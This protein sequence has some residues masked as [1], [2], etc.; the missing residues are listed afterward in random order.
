MAGGEDD[1]DLYSDEDED[2]GLYSDD[3]ESEAEAE[4]KEQ[5]GEVLA[6]LRTLTIDGGASAAVAADDLPESD[7]R[8]CV[9]VGVDQIRR[10]QLDLEQRGGGELYA[11]VRAYLEAREAKC[12]D[13][14]DSAPSS[15]TVKESMKCALERKFG[16]G[17]L[18][19]CFQ[20]EQLLYLERTCCS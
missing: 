11:Q 12:G 8:H 10:F 16:R 2:G 19:F 18:D 13:A 4:S 14:G 15:E 1:D 6:Q 20:V 5:R 9:G 3:F 7:Q 17:K